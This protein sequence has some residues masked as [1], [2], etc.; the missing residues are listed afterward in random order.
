MHY[1][2]SFGL[3]ATKGLGSVHLANN[4]LFPDQYFC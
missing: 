4:Y 1:I 3:M 2:I